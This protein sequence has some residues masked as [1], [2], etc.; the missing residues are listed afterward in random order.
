MLTGSER[1]HL[2]ALCR[3]C[4]ELLSNRVCND[5]PVPNTDE[6]W[7]TWERMHADNLRLTVEQWR[8]HREYEPRPKGDVL[9]FYDWWLLQYLARRL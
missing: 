5:F 4:S 6:N 8:A 1:E 7:T 3:L 2:R 9:Y